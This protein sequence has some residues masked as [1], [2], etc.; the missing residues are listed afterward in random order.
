[1]TITA[2]DAYYAGDLEDF[3]GEA[4]DGADAVFTIDLR[5]RRKRTPPRAW[6]V[7]EKAELLADLRDE[8]RSTLDDRYRAED[9]RRRAREYAARV[10]FERHAFIATNRG[11]A[12]LVRARIRYRLAVDPF[13]VI[14][15]GALLFGALMVA[16]AVGFALNVWTLGF[17]SIAAAF[18]TWGAVGIIDSVVSFASGR[19]QAPLMDARLSALLIVGALGM[20]IITIVAALT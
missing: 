9:Q 14:R 19:R 8:V 10:Y 18:S 6:Q 20:A 13:V 7:V 16:A 17:L 3:A 1:M 12:W 11:W 5:P 2:E 4:G 15:W